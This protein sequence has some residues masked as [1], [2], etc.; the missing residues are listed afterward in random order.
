LGHEAMVR[1]VRASRQIH[2]RSIPTNTAHRNALLYRF[3]L[4]AAAAVFT[5]TDSIS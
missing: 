3:T 1:T 2:I 5:R 4:P